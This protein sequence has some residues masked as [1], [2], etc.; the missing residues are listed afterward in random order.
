MLQF[1]ET[2][3]RHRRSLKHDVKRGAGRAVGRRVAREAVRR[4]IGAC[5]PIHTICGKLCG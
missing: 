3:A 2:V 1:R 5:P 4:L